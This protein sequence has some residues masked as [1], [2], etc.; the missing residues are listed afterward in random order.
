MLIS[1]I[2]PTYNRSKYL[3]KNLKLLYGH[4]Q[5]IKSV[6]FEIVVSNNASNDDTDKKVHEFISAH[7]D[8]SVNYFLQKTNLGVAKNCLFVCEVAKGDFIIYLGDDDYMDYNYLNGVVD[9]LL[10]NSNTYSIIPSIVEVDMEGNHLKNGR[11]FEYPNTHYNS[12]FRNCKINSW[13]GHQLSGLVLKR[14]QLYNLY[15]K[16]EIGNMYIFIH[17]LAFNC[18]RGD[19]Y[20]FTEFPVRVTNPGQKNKDWTYGEDGLINEI[21]DNYNN[22]PINHYQKTLLQ[23]EVIRR[24]PWRLWRYKKIGN[25]EFYGTL[26]NMW[27]SKNSTFLFKVMFPFEILKISIKKKLYV[28]LKS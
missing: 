22:L 11:D 3:L 10:K 20:H 13:R 24:Q 18:L 26:K 16:K 28:L 17:F 12:G 8:V 6:K 27:F 5:A 21:F 4:I 14:D 23:L 2:I 15:H 25:K 7:P 19:T 9:H 1:I